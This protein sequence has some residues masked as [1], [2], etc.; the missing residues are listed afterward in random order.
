MNKYQEIMDEA[1]VALLRALLDDQ[2]PFG[3]V[4][5][6]SDDWEYPL[7]LEV[8][9]DH[10]LLLNIKGW[11]LEQSYITDKKLWLRV[12]FGDSENGRYFSPDE[13][14]AVVGED[15]GSLYHR[16][17]DS[18]P[19]VKEYTMKSLMDMV[20]DPSAPDIENSM[21]AMRKNNPDIGKEGTEKDA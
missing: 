3:V 20:P 7:P 17:F 21:N 10:P 18:T 6:W 2:E 1:L 13:I 8:P 16:V 19:P 4:V 12:A 11:S 5:S 15:G 14:L 9:T